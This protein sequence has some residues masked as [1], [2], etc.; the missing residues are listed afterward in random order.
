MT[1]VGP[2]PNFVINTGTKLVITGGVIRLI[3]LL[4]VSGE[5]VSFLSVC[6]NESLASR[7]RAGAAFG[8]RAV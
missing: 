5:S 6:E 2:S 4:L 8:N 1:R 7:L 3:P